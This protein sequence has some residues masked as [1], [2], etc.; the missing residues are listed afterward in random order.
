MDPQS[1]PVMQPRP[2]QQLQWYFPAG[3]QVCPLLR[4][5]DCHWMGQILGL[6][7]PTTQC[8]LNH[9]LGRVTVQC[10]CVRS[11]IFYD[12]SGDNTITAAAFLTTRPPTWG[13]F[14]AV[15]VITCCCLLGSGTTRV[16]RV[17]LS[18]LSTL[19]M[20]WCVSSKRPLKLC[21]RYEVLVVSGVLHRQLHK[22]RRP[23]K[24]QLHK[25]VH[26]LLLQFQCPR[27]QVPQQ[28]GSHLSVPRI[29]VAS[30]SSARYHFSPEQRLPGPLTGLV[31][32]SL[33][34]VTRPTRSSSCSCS[35][36]R[37]TA[38]QVNAGVLLQTG[39]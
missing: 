39:A 17:V 5:A 35:R 4:F 33:T 25:S 8:A 3:L 28:R 21:V 2:A 11:W 32:A 29:L 30:D 15:S 7:N 16:S 22:I 34:Q 18:T 9:A 37:S 31:S 24:F 38:G 12:T 36:S 6:I 14:G 13:S 23:F 19:R 1:T 20:V 26:Q 27:P 10:V